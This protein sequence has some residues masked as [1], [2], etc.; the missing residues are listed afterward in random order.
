MDKYNFKFARRSSSTELHNE[1]VTTRVFIKGYSGD[2]M[3][4]KEIG[5]PGSTEQ[6]IDVYNVLVW[7][8]QSEMPCG[9]VSLDWTT[10]MK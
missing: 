2:E 8:L 10:I 1:D 7:K 3:K 5:G 9:I 6:K 4:E